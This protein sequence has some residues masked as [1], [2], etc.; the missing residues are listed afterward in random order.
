[1]VCFIGYCQQ[2]N[3]EF[4]IAGDEQAGSNL[5]KI[6]RKKYNLSESHFIGRVN[7][8]EYLSQH[9]DDVLFVGGVGLVIL[10]AAYLNYP[11]LCCSDWKGANYS[12]ITLSNI[13]LFDNFTIRKQSLVTLNGKK[14]FRFDLEKLNNYGVRNYI[15]S[16]R[17]FNLI[18]AKY[19][20]IIGGKKC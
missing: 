16:N 8:L 9:I 2:Q 20:N 1:M 3:I 17:A 19:L 15:I 18:T 12:F 10:E 4:E 5:K 7:T 6:L 11:C 13:D 14:E